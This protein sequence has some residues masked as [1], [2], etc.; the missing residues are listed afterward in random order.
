[1][2]YS[3]PVKVLII[4]PLV[5]MKRISDGGLTQKC[6]S[7]PPMDATQADSS[8]LV[9]FTVIQS[10]S[11]HMRKGPFSKAYIFRACG[12]N[13]QKF[14]FRYF[15]ISSS[16]ESQLLQNVFVIFTFLERKF[17]TICVQGKI[18]PK[19]ACSKIVLCS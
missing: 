12:T 2:P 19:K 4:R 9:Q 6:G 10:K 13:W 11:S 17:Q 5:K 7:V 15:W 14:I 16:F 3:N 18:L 8:C 1:M